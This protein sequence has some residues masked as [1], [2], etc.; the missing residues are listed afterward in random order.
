MSA[1]VFLILFLNISNFAYFDSS[2]HGTTAMEVLKLNTNPRCVSM[3]EA[4]AS[5]IDDASSIEIN[6]ANLVMIKRNSFFISH[7][8]FFSDIKM[9]NISYGRKLAKNVGSFGFSAKI[10]NW[11][12]IEETN[13]SAATLGSFSPKDVI[14]TLGFANYIT[15]LTKDIEERI[16]FGGTVKLISTRIKNSATTVSSDIAFKFPYLFDRRFIISLVM[17]N[18]IGT[19]KIDKERYG[20]TK[21]FRIATSTLVSK[22]ITINSDIIMPE[23]SFLYLSLGVEERINLSKI[24]NIALRAGINTRNIKDLDGNR[25]INLG[26]GIKYLNYKLD[27]S[28]SPFGDLGNIHRISISINF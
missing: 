7:S 5:D 18:L 3:G 15:G 20:I 12:S 22:N 2:S 21:V 1:V 23:D 6:P 19:I 8:E 16:V 9:E 27:Y 17:Q 11:G 10:L 28:Y 13:D 14:L 25:T 24:S 4:C 26:F